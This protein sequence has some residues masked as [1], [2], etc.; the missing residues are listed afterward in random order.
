MEAF[1]ASHRKA[2]PGEPSESG[3]PSGALRLFEA[4]LARDPA[5]ARSWNYVG[6]A[7]FA[8]GDL[9]RAL[10]HFR[11]AVELDP[12]LAVAHYQLAVWTRRFGGTVADQRAS[13][14]LLKGFHDIEQNAWR[15]TMQKFTVTLR[16]PAGASQ[17]GATLQVKLVIPDPVI[18]QLKTISLSANIE[19][20]SL[21][22]ETYAKPGEYVYSRDVPATVLASDAVTVDFTLDKALR[23]SAADAREL[24]IIISSIGFEPK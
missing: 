3:D 1:L 21:P 13:L 16:P 23:P 5:R 24:G 20:T 10:E 18:A 12:T 22:G 19:G 4:A 11:R 15:W 14:Q 2:G 8:I 17:R 7:H 9:S 6:G